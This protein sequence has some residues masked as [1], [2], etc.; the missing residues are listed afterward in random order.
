MRARW[1][2]TRLIGDV[3]LRTTVYRYGR[4]DVRIDGFGLSQR[5]GTLE[6]I[7]RHDCHPLLDTATE[8]DE[9]DFDPLEPGLT[10]IDFDPTTK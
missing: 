6:A 2:T 3:A 9:S 1:W 7:E 4:H 8:I 5:W 10:P